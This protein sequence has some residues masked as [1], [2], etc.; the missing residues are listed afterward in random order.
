MEVGVMIAVGV[1]HLIWIVWFAFRMNTI[2]DRVCKMRSQLKDCYDELTELRLSARAIQKLI[3]GAVRERAGEV[4][5]NEGGPVVGDRQ[6]STGGLEEAGA[7]LSSKS[8]RLGTATSLNRPPAPSAPQWRV[9]A[10]NET[11]QPIIRVVAADTRE[12]ARAVVLLDGLAVQRVER[13]N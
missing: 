6:Q 3:D 9:T 7:G 10:T 4:G 11:G 1:I 12:E 5:R 2:E 8:L 13:I